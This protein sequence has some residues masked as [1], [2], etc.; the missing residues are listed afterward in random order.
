M[1]FFQRPRIMEASFLA[2]SLRSAQRINAPRLGHLISRLRGRVLSA[3][4][5][6]LPWGHLCA[7]T[8]TTTTLAI[9][10][11]RTLDHP[12]CRGSRW[13]R[14]VRSPTREFDRISPMFEGLIILRLA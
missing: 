1:E 6:C 2:H 14:T 9:I 5:P 11:L 4:T 13:A 3:R 7:A 8:I 10:L 12:V